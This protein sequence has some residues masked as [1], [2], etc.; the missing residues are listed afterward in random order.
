MCLPK[1]K[2]KTHQQLIVHT[3]LL[4]ELTG[5]LKSDFLQSP[6]FSLEGLMASELVIKV[7]YKCGGFSS[8]HSFHSVGFVLLWNK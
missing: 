5:N 4:G 6:E 8:K 1:V 3:I 2:K 7:P